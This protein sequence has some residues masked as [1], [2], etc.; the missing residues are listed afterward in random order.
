MT[1]IDSR[2]LFTALGFTAVVVQ[3]GRFPKEEGAKRAI[4]FA[5]LIEAFCRDSI[6]EAFEGNGPPHAVDLVPT[7]SQSIFA[8]AQRMATAI[9]AL[10]REQGG[11]LP[12]DLQ[13]KGF[14]PEEVE[15]QWP[16]ANAL[17]QVALKITDA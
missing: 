6:P 11:C 13:A 15:R 3:G 10:Y 14:T 4:Q 12:Q 2:L 7:E 8:I 17:A 1:F 9:V 16:M 5:S